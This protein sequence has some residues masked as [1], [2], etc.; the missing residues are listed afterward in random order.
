MIYNKGYW[1]VSGIMSVISM[2]VMIAAGYV[3]I[4]L[5]YQEDDFFIILSITAL[6]VVNVA[7]YYLILRISRDS[8][9]INRNNLINQ[10]N[11]MII[12]HYKEMEAAEE[13]V[14]RIKA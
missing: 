10:H 3:Q 7:V 6:F 11:N 12:N 9:T 1:W 13:K 14:K 4:T 8:I 2:I 5:P